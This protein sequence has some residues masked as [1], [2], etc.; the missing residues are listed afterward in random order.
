MK[1]R[2]PVSSNEDDESSNDTSKE[3]RTDWKIQKLEKETRS[4]ILLLRRI[5]QKTK[6]GIPLN[7]LERKA[8][9]K[10][11]GEHKT[12]PSEKEPYSVSP[13][14]PG[15]SIVTRNVESYMWSLWL[16]TCYRYTDS[17]KET[18]DDF[19]EDPNFTI[20]MISTFVTL[21]NA[22]CDKLGTFRNFWKSFNSLFAMD[23]VVNSDHTPLTTTIKQEPIYFVFTPT[24][25]D[26]KL[27]AREEDYYDTQSEV[28][29][30]K[31]YILLIVNVALIKKMLDSYSDEAGCMGNT[32]DI[33]IVDISWDKAPE[34][35][36]S[37][38]I[39]QQRDFKMEKFVKLL[40]M[41][42]IHGLGHFDCFI[43]DNCCYY[44]NHSNKS[45]F[46]CLSSAFIKQ[47]Q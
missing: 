13:V 14:A 45:K 3:T 36:T 1:T 21:I 40:L 28:H 34:N 46:S 38:G 9:T 29:L 15:A 32:S 5:L 41:F 23:I 27:E 39:N 12:W 43:K 35:C 7:K 20:E 25:V 16:S 26:T 22:V 18:T 8:I 42:I 10:D 33:G 11:G 37:L 17:L 24:Y 2:K 4:K 31:R 44:K 47:H 6:K 30:K 19:F